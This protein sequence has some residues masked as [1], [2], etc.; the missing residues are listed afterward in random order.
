MPLLEGQVIN[1]ASLPTHNLN[2]RANTSPATVG[3][4]RM[5]LS[6]QQSRTQ[7][8]NGAPYALFGDK[9]GN[10]NA[11][12][13]AVGNYT[14]TGNTFNGSNATGQAGGSLTISFKVV[15]QAAP[16][17]LTTQPTAEEP[18]EKLLVYPNPFQTS[19]ILELGQQQQTPVPVVLYDGAGRKVYEQTVV[20]SKPLIEPGNGLAPGLYL[21]E[22]GQ[23]TSIQRRKLLKTP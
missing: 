11:W 8:D 16:A 7:V 3:S 2:I 4:V 6:G 18:T 15:S 22:V 5:V 21:L 17:R 1:L 12:T 23:G 19:F 20:E 9:S 14:L 10:Y 13:P